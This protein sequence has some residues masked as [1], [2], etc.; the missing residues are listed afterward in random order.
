MKAGELTKRA[1][2]RKANEEAAKKAREEGDLELAEKFQRRINRITPEMTA[3]CK[4]LFDLMGVPVVEA[5]CEAEAQCAELVKNGGVYATASEDMDSLTF[6]TTRLIRHIWQ[7]T[8]STAAK[9]GIKPTEFN[10]PMLLEDLDMPMEQ[11]IDMCILCG[12]D[13]VDSIRGVG[14]VT[15]LKLI[16]DVKDLTEVVSNLRADKGYSVP[17]AYPVDAIREMFV[18]PVVTPSSEISLKWGKPDLEKLRTFM[19]VENQFDPLK[20][21][22]GIK[23]LTASRKKC[24]QG[25]VDSFFK[26]VS[27]P[28][29]AERA[30]KRKA[31]AD[32][33]K[34]KKRKR[35]ANGTSKAKKS[36]KSA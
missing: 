20:M 22:N 23:R 19:V 6:G 35:V 27:A 33:D 10:L 4:T 1:E 28:N 5:P 18:K 17:D 14:P 36:K 12:C 3:S 9:K 7:G 13:Y 8:A 26:R 34:V 11:F 16:R 15:A 25:R 31:M 30:Q 24:D 32:A 21:E 29:D 2:T